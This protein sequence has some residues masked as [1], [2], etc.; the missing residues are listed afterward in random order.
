MWVVAV[1]ILRNI[2]L[3]IGLLDSESDCWALK[4]NGPGSLQRYESY[5]AANRDHNLRSH[6]THRRHLVD[7]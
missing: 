4:R 1:R 3:P 5:A 2:V 6:Q 7:P